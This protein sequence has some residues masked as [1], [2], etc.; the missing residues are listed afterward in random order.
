[1][2]DSPVVTPSPVEPISRKARSGTSPP[3]A[4]T[5]AALWLWA[6]GRAWTIG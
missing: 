6:G 3:A 5:D 2:P 1:M 4:A